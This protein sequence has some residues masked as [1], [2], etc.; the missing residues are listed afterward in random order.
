MSLTKPIGGEAER[1]RESESTSCSNTVGSKR[2]E[3]REEETPWMDNY[4]FEE[5]TS[6]ALKKLFGY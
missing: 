4:L 1:E 2:I 6:N 5:R 3:E